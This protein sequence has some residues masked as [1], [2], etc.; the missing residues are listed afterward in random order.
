MK[1]KYF[2]QSD[3]IT[4]V[5]SFNQIEPDPYVRKDVMGQEY[6]D[7]SKKSTR[8]I[9]DF[10]ILRDYVNAVNFTHHLFIHLRK[11]LNPSNGIV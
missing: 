11:Q 8:N 5:P 9:R 2:H 6:K 4:V 7:I 10:L 1:V 3:V